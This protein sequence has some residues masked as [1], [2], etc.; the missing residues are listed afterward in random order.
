ML[1]V[2]LHRYISHLLSIFS[3]YTKTNTNERKRFLAYSLT[4]IV[5]DTQGVYIDIKSS[6][7]I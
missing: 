4:K 7:G 5:T 3:K 6:V 2:L 1:Y